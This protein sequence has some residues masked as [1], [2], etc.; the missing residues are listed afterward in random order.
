MAGQE[1]DPELVTTFA[2][3]ALVRAGKADKAQGAQVY[4]QVSEVPFGVG[5]TVT[6]EMGSR[7]KSRTMPALLPEAR[8]RMATLLWGRFEAELGDIADDPASLWDA[9]LGFFNVAAVEVGE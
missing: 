5:K 4:E 7:R 2:V 1:H 6:F 3:I 9:R 8:A